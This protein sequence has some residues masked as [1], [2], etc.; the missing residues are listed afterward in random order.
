M[1][2]YISGS[3]DT[4]SLYKLFH[5]RR[6]LSCQKRQP[7]G[8]RLIYQQFWQSSTWG[9]FITPTNLVSSTKHIQISI[10]TT[11]VNVA[12]VES[13]ASWGWPDCMLDCLPMFVVGKST[14]PHCFSG[15]KSLPCRY[16]SI[17]KG[18]PHLEGRRG[19]SQKQAATGK[20]QGGGSIKCQCPHWKKNDF[21]FFNYFLEIL[22]I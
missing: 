13:I 9:V 7:V 14:K 2:G 8:M 21:H 3:R 10:C 15:V 5:E 22:S 20:G 6:T 18:C 4:M 19:V 1:G 16:G 12:V 11:K 17:H